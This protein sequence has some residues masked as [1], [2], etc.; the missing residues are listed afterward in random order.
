MDKQSFKL[1]KKNVFIGG[2]IFSAVC[3]VVSVVI[4][5]FDGKFL[6]GLA[7]GF[8]TM[9][10]NLELLGRLVD[11]YVRT[12]KIGLAILLYI[13]RLAIYAAVAVVCYM[14]SMYALLA[15][16]IGVFGIVVGALVSMKKE[17]IKKV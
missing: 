17:A 10:I 1:M 15:F 8:I 11:F 14:L 3:E 5:G 7:M 12:K 2:L 16:A 13:A 9:I 6:G 4:I